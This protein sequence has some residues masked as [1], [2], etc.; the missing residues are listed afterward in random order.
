MSIRDNIDRAAAK[1][2]AQ[3]DHIYAAVDLGTNNCRLLVARPSVEGFRVVD[4]FSRIV[5][6]GEGVEASKRLSVEAMDRT[7]VAL[8][9]CA[10]KMRRRRVTRARCVATAACRKALNCDEFLA[11]VDKEAGLYLETITA[12]EEAG[13]AIAGCRSL[14]EAQARHALVF[15][16]GGGSTELIW[17]VHHPDT[18]IEPIAL[19]SLPIG[20]VS[21]AERHGGG[22]FSPE[23]FESLVRHL[24]EDMDA[25]EAA[26]G[27]NEK[28]RRGGVQ[29]IGTSGT[30]TTLSGV[31]LGL[32]K[33]DRQQVDGLWL[34]FADVRSAAERLRRMSLEQRAAHPCIGRGRADLVV[35]GCAILEA[36]RRTWPCEKLRVADRGVR[37][38]LLLSLI[39][40]DSGRPG[41][42]ATGGAII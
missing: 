28:M 4:A 18:G 7:I 11:R 23:Q 1:P 40:S 17:A 15:D 2:P 24:R 38:G 20:V 42:G 35:A 36:I 37:E 6:L 5:R 8:K 3:V 30:V 33:Y 21:I 19:A 31:H 25:F 27:I 14:L 26:H 41:N 34:S 32:E 10:D 13:L 12:E 22:E 29:M 16:I 9:I 39:R